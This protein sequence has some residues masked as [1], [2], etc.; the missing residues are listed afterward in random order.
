[1]H[2]FG[3][4]GSHG[5][6]GPAGVTVSPSP[7]VTADMILLGNR[8]R[9]LATERGVQ[10][11]ERASHMTV[12]QSGQ[13]IVALELRATATSPEL[14]QGRA[15][16][17]RSRPSSVGAAAGAGSGARAGPASACASRHRCSSTPPADEACCAGSRRCCARW[18]PTVR[19]DEL[20][21]ASDHHLRVADPD[22]AER[23]LE[24]YGA[25]PG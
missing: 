4:D 8:L 20:C 6:D 22:G 2:M 13:R 3:P 9:G 15:V 11:L 18:C 14:G 12:E 5:A 19:G 23:F 24:R 25:T 1:M 10:F 21:S 7:I 16:T 17:R